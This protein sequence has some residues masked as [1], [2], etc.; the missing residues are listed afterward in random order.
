MLG[1]WGEEVLGADGGDEGDDVDVVREFEVFLGDGAGGDA[2][3]SSVISLVDILSG[4]L[5]VP[6][7]SRALLRP[8]PLLALT[9]Y[10]SR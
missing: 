10:F 5:Y 2:A 1:G 7:V 6:M 4:R 3:C 9:P 8:P